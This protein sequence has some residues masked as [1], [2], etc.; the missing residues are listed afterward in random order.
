MR[1]TDPVTTDSDLPAKAQAL[2]DAV[3]AISTD[4]DLHSVLTRIVESACTLT[5]AE[6]GALGIVGADENLSDFITTGLDPHTRALIGDLPSGRG[7]LRLLIDEPEPIRLTDLREHERSYGFPPGHPTMITFLGVPVRIRGTVFGNLYLTQKTGGAPFSDQ[8]EQLVLGLASAAGFVIEN[9][10]AYGLSERRRQWLE[11]SAEL[12]AGLQPPI[13]QDRAL[14]QVLSGA[15]RISRASATALVQLPHGGSPTVVAME[16]YDADGVLELVLDRLEG[17]AAGEHDSDPVVELGLDGHTVVVLPLRAHLAEA[18][19]LVSVFD[20]ARGPEAYDELEL[21]ASF[22]DQAALA[23]DRAQAMQ[24]RQ[25]LAVVSDRDRIARDLHD[26]VI[27][28]LFSTGM[29]LQ[30]LRSALPRTPTE[31]VADRLDQAVDDLDVTVKNIRSTIFA[32]QERRAGSLR[33]DL[34]DLVQEYVPVLGIR[35]ELRTRGPI[36]TVVDAEIRAQLLAVVR[37]ALSNVARH[38]VAD[39]AS[40]E[41]EATAKELVV[42]VTDDGTGVSQDR[43]ESGLRN[44]RRRAQ[45]LGGTFQL[46]HAHPHG[47]V[48]EWRVPLRG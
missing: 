1:E 45:A 23:L 17:F 11:A 12:A 13:D 8:D 28:R 27:Q 42:R 44:A 14:R 39:H 47:T 6:Y 19:M 41:V 7:I 43:T 24:E 33:S 40:L 5:G 18:G 46:R 25:E 35:P 26:I 15:R 34:R 2:L 22:A 9:A 3:V 29:K 37:E 4:L 30:G 36:D 48:F 21:L 10:R 20:R 32:L 31:D 16:G 38:A